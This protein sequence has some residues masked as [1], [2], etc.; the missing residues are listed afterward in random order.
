[1]NWDAIGAIGEVTGAL[2][3]F[4]TLVYLAVQLRQNARL[5]RATIREQRTASSHRI[6][7][8]TAQHD[9]DPETA[10]LSLLHASFRK[11]R[12]DWDTYSRQRADGLIDDE[13]WATQLRI[14]HYLLTTDPL[15]K[16]TR[17][18]MGAAYSREL[19]D[20]VEDALGDA[21]ALAPRTS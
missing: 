10:R 11:V 6:Q 20:A 5:M 19:R 15:I 2:A 21:H 18:E 3:V 14:W 13:E 4:V 12:R 1:M 16:G 8:H 9:P 17:D 7:L